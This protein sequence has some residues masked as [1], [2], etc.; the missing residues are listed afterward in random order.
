MELQLIELYS[1]VCL[2]YDKHPM[3]KYQRLSNNRQPN[4]TDQELIPV[5]LFGQLQGHFKQKRIHQYISQHFKAWFPDLPVY[6]TFNYRLNSIAE[7]FKVIVFESF[8]EINAST[9][10]YFEEDCLIDSMPIML[11]AGS[12]SYHAKVAVEI[13]DQSYSH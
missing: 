4:F 11:A 13:A 2:V 5:Y 3:L 12:R 1:W 10:N 9:D 7:S 8:T 6:Q